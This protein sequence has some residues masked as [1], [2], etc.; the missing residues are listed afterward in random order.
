MTP[1]LYSAHTYYR[2]TISSGRAGCDGIS[3]LAFFFSLL[4][5]RRLQF[6][7]IALPPSVTVEPLAALIEHLA[8]HVSQ[9]CD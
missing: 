9:W 1:H 4:P 3:A 6:L 5:G 7:A 2:R 8:K